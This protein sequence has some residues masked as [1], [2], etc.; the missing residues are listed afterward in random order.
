MHKN[1]CELCSMDATFKKEIGGVT[2]FYCDHHKIEG[3]VKILHMVQKSEFQKLLPL[4][5][6]FGLI[7]I[8]VTGTLYIQ[9]DFSG[10][11][12]MMLFMAYFFFVFGLFKVVNLKN[13]TEAYATYDVL[14]M[15]S[16]T[17]AYLYPFIEIGLGIM[18]FFYL[19]GVYRDVFTFVIMTIG[20]YG[21]WKALSN[22]EEIPCACLGM[23]FHV[24]MTKVTLFENL[25]MAVMALYMV[26]AY[27][28]MGNMA[29]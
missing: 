26:L 4:L 6:I 28:Q 15:K 25:F 22:K 16:K 2:H 5:S 17:Y 1:K 13:F 10:M 27:L 23:V 20:T 3:S 11:N 14:A 18:Y 8:L 29:M 9:S 12:I 19:G 21:V 24:P 7:A